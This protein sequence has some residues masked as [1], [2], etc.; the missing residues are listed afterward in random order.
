MRSVPWAKRP[1]DET[2]LTLQD[3]GAIFVAFAVGVIALTVMV[4]VIAF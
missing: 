3:L 2:E 1:A 4:R